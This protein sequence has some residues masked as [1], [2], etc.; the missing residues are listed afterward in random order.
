MSTARARVARAARTAR[1]P[2]A[3]VTALAVVAL[4][5]PG[6]AVTAAVTRSSTVVG[7]HFGAT[8]VVDVGVHDLTVTHGSGRDRF[9]PGES[10]TVAFRATPADRTTVPADLRPGDQLS[11]SVT[12]PSWLVPGQLPAST[13][14][15]SG[16]S[17]WS[18][19][20]SA[21]DG[22][23]TVTRTSTFTG[24][25][26]TFSAATPFTFPVVA[27]GV[28]ADGTVS[29]TVGTPERMAS[30][31]VSRSVAV[32]GI[33][34][35]DVGVYDLTVVPTGAQRFA[36]GTQGTVRFHST[37]SPGTTARAADFR[38]GEAVVHEITLPAWLE[39]GTLPVINPAPWSQSV[40]TSSRDEQTGTWTVRRTQNLFQDWPTFSTSLLE[41]P[42]R[43]SS[44]PVE[45]TL[46]RAT[47]ALPGNLTS[48]HGADETDAM[49]AQRVDVGVYDLRV[50]PTTG[51]DFLPGLTGTLA[52]RTTPDAGTVP[53]RLDAGD[54]VTHTVRVPSWLEVTLPADTATVTW[55]TAPGTGGTTTVTRAEVVGAGT[56]HT[57]THVQLA[58][59]AARTG[60]G[61][62]TASA[63]VTLPSHAVSRRGTDSVPVTTTTATRVGV[64]D[65]AVAPAGG[66]RFVLGASGQVTFRAAQ[67]AGV[68]FTA[69]AGDTL[70]HRVVLPAGLVPGQPQSEAPGSWSTVTWTRSEDE[71]GTWTVTRTEEFTQEV[72]DHLF[73]TD[74]TLVIPVTATSALRDGSLVVAT[75]SLP[76]HLTSAD[77]TASVPVRAI[78]T[79]EVGVHDLR[80]TPVA[81]IAFLP[82]TRGTLRFDTTPGGA[83]AAARLAAGDTVTHTV[84]LP[85]WLAADPLPPSS[86]DVRWSS[87]AGP[88]GT[89]LTR[90]QTVTAAQTQF[91][92]APVEIPVV[93]S[94]DGVTPSPGAV[95]ASVALPA[96]SLPA[97]D[98]ATSTVLVPS[99][100]ETTVGI[101]GL[102]AAPSTG[103]VF[104]VGGTGAA[105]FRA[106]PS[107]GAPF[108]A[109][110]GDTLVHRI[111]FPE[112]LVPGAL[113]ATTTT[114]VS[115]TTWS[116]ATED[117]VRTVTRTEQFDREVT[118]GTYDT[119][120]TFR[121][122]VTATGALVHGAELRGTATVPG[123]LTSASAVQHVAVGAVTPTAVGV[124][125]LTVTPV[126]ATW[127]QPGAAGTLAFDVTPD[128]T[129]T[130]A[131]IESGDAVVHTI[132]LP[133]W[134]SVD[135][136]PGPVSTGDSTVTWTQ[137]P[138]GTGPLVRMETFSGARA[139]YPATR[140]ELPLRT[141]T[142]TA[143]ADATVTVQVTLPAHSRSTAG[144]ANVTAKASTETQVGVHELTVTP[145]GTTAFGPGSVGTVSFLTTPVASTPVAYTAAAGTRL[146]HTV[147]LPSWLEPGTLPVEQGAVWTQST[148]GGQRRV[149]RT[150]TLS[151]PTTT[152]TTGRLEFPVAVTATGTPRDGDQV[153]GEATV[154]SSLTTRAS[155]VT[156]TVRATTQ[157]SDGVYN[158]TV[159]P[160]AGTVFRRGTFGAVS[161][162]VG[163]STPN[164][165]ALTYASGESRTHEVILP[166]YLTPTVPL[167]PS[168]DGTSTVSW[169]SRANPDGTWRVTRTE[170]FQRTS[171]STAN[172]VISFEVR[173]ATVLP[174]TQ[175]VASASATLP[176]GLTSVGGGRAVTVRH[177][178]DPVPVGVFNLAVGDCTSSTAN[179]IR[180]GCWFSWN[181]TPNGDVYD[182]DLRAGDVIT[183]VA[184]AAGGGYLDYRNFEWD[185]R[186]EADTDEYRITWTPASASLDGVTS[187]TRTIEIK[188]DLTRFSVPP[189]RLRVS[190]FP[191]PRQG[192]AEFT[193]TG[194]SWPETMGVAEH[195]RLAPDVIL[196]L[197]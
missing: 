184:T 20:C 88:G 140:V 147:T 2:A 71:A 3:V 35:V 70:V 21:A 13:S 108:T 57:G 155:P 47:V 36:E 103:Q 86:D 152:S 174:S 34:H 23:C 22:A 41:F 82:G 69:S 110:A 187:A 73:R 25:Q 11:F 32:R 170:A 85:T 139:T 164:V 160:V 12:L 159:A 96:H 122:A 52:F 143:A 27:Q 75:A 30:T 29:G 190:I 167:L 112:G 131:R 106:V 5:V 192:V 81:G 39:P 153:I 144:N 64:Y 141:S 121:I 44:T 40:W 26:S 66:G 181:V 180:G 6:L 49:A 16:R 84:T 31:A 120:A 129:D 154:A 105:E 102:G 92:T 157:A 150:V 195:E 89:T 90:T 161:F 17:E 116:S 93:A 67:T 151:A 194:L 78:H 15:A 98:G 119:D 46:V 111:E 14:F 72:G 130:S 91:R 99:T 193:V 158:F 191:T 58:V 94:Y 114:D 156:A 55:T 60:L 59:R 176:R 42:V 163:P 18:Q 189:T 7:N 74:A 43:A 179:P 80:V 128:R 186:V 169:T 133:S 48:R 185:V 8:D 56:S 10:G 188:K 127:F 1:L 117:G 109:R 62:T 162:Q 53:V 142:S 146:V 83:P 54:V 172:P 97:D 107:G 123:H 9:R 87:T 137:T 113:P 50:S 118:S 68:P 63:E 134:L 101:H 166:A 65:L 45:G 175:Q 115:T 148:V 124:H 197:Y 136:L 149:T 37:P 165:N 138:A 61:N 125:G 132:R 28:L 196:M 126:A 76:D 51:T 135:P 104:G 145:S 100:A 95:V 182:V 171:R 177:T 77:P 24:T 19:D 38:D 183:Q 168:S 178:Q 79:V 33:S 4:V 173:A